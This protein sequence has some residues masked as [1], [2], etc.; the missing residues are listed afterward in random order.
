VL[1]AEPNPR[2]VLVVGDRPDSE[3]RAARQLGMWT[4][5]RLGGEFARYRP[6]HRLEK[7]H[8]SIRKLSSLFRLSLEFRGPQAS[9]R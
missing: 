9:R 2:R 8:F 4:V 7:P 6:R 1:R 5:R 3:I